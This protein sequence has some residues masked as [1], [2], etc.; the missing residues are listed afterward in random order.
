MT[1]RLSFQAWSVGEICTTA[2]AKQEAERF[3]DKKAKW[4]FS[5]FVQPLKHLLMHVIIKSYKLLVDA[6]LM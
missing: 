3:P 6:Q 2:S 1:N 5:Q 4:Q